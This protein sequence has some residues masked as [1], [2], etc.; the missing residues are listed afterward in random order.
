[1]K[2]LRRIKVV[3]EPYMAKWESASNA[4]DWPDGKSRWY[5]FEQGP[6]SII[7]RPCPEYPVSGRGYYQIRGLAWSGNG[8]IRKVEV[9]TD[10][11][12]S[13]KEA[14]LEQPVFRMAFTRFS[15]DW[16]WNGEEVVLQSRCTDETGEVQPTLAQLGKVKGVAPDQLR[17]YFEFP[18]GRRDHVNAI[19]PWRVS[20]DGSVRN[21]LF[22]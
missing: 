16:N 22:S 2:Y 17:T 4:D 18:S 8:A 13:W 9:S 14:Q 20:R 5:R 6:R 19:Q 10:G 15:L 11:G 7:L 1:M 12:R 21:A 3:D